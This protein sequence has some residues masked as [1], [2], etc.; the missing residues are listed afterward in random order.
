MPKPVKTFLPAVLL[1]VTSVCGSAQTPAPELASA[2]N[3]HQ[4]D[5]TALETQRTAALEQVQRPYAAA[6]DAAEKTATATGSLPAVAA[7]T[8]ERAALKSGLMAPEFPEGLPKTLQTTRKTYLDDNTRT[9]ASEATRQAAV[10]AEYLRALAGLQSKAAA[11]PELAQQLAAEKEK[12]LANAA[13]AGAPANS[14]ESRRS[15]VVNG[16][17]DLA[18]ADGRP[19]G[20]TVPNVEGVSFKVVRDG[21]NNVLHATASGEPRPVYVSQEFPVPAHAKS[22]TVKG[23]VRGKWENRDTKDSN[24]GATIDGS[25]I[26]ADDQKFGG[27]IILVGGRE[28]GWKTL[29]KTQDLPK[30]AKTY[31]VHFGFQFVSGTFDFDDISVEFR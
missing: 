3:K 20:W 12:L 15:V 6:L 26:G 11:N 17:F 5:R 2:A 27:W 21:S 14:A 16:T 24:W 13:V 30:E 10:D 4:A 9:R 18:E 7:I 28:P 8:K 19:K 22:V 1:L 31:H 29:G 25:A 23:R